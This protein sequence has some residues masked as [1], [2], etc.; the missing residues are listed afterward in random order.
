MIAVSGT[1]LQA[2]AYKGICR[3]GGWR[4]DGFTTE[5]TEDTER[6]KERMKDEG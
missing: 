4:T 1:W 5:G 3:L 2:K 6:M